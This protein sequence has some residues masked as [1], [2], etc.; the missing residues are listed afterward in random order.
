MNALVKQQAWAEFRHS[1]MLIGA[2]GRSWLTLVRLTWRWLL[3][4]GLTA[5]SL[6]TFLATTTAFMPVFTPTSRWLRR[7]N[8]LA[9]LASHFQPHYLLIFISITT[10]F[11]L[12]KRY[13]QGALTA[14]FSLIS[15][16]L[17]APLYLPANIT[18]QPTSDTYRAIIFNVY[19]DNN[20][21]EKTLAFL[22]QTKPDVIV[23]ADILEGWEPAL[24]PLLDQYPYSNHFDSHDYHGTIIYSRFPFTNEV[25]VEPI[26]DDRRSAA[27]TT[28]DVNGQPLTL[29]A[30]HTR[31]PVRVGRMEQR[32]QQIR[33]L[34]AALA[35]QT[36][37]T[38]LLGDLNTTPWSPIFREFLAGSRLQN[39]RRG[40]GLQASWPAPLGAFGIPIDHVLISPEISIHQ[41]A[42]GADLGSDHYPIV[43]DFSFSPLED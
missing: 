31:S 2:L 12:R 39:G 42:R 15:L 5:V 32:N 9:D 19:T 25:G 30:A 24:L 29:M 34:K 8:W 7:L 38:L 20:D 26:A 33:D 11:L 6:L 1:L 27:L 43:V 40:F 10:L 36:G 16:T 14:V 22:D 13:Q 35:H 41:L 17:I 21:Y 3:W 37:P 18:A 23:L 28:L 4:N